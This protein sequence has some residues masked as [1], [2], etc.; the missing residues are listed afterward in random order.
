[1]NSLKATSID[2]VNMKVKNLEQSVKFY[3]NLFGFEIKQ[4]ENANKLDVPSK[5]IGNDAIKLCMYE[6]PDMSP[7]G[8]IAHF[9]FNVANFNEIIE[10]CEE[11]KVE[12]LYGGIVDWETSKSVYIVD[13]SGYEIELGM[14]L[15]GGL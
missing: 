5:I 15:G 1:M 11:L 4:E 2:H 14:V 7:E 8:G 6:I 9:G 3:K 13:P 10:K 12:V